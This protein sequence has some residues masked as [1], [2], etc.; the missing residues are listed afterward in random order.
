VNVLE[1]PNGLAELQKLGVRSV[2]VLSRGDK[3]TFGQSTK[4]IVEFLGLNENAGPL[5]S[6]DELA[7]RLD[8]FMGAA[9]ELIPLMPY[10][11]LAT[12]VPGRP[13]SYRTLAFHLFRVVDAF[14]GANEGTTLVQDMFREEPAP[15]ADAATLV[16]WGETVRRRFADWWRKGDAS[17]SKPLPTYYGPQSLHELMERTTWHCG[18]HVRQYMMLL[19]KEG[20]RHREPL[21]PADF[22]K[23]P[24]PTN[25]WDG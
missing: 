12:H 19:D 7:A 14:I 17:P 9:L 23:L 1:D 2:P 25:V 11:K 10:D 6:T 24:M 5:L 22:A 21:G 20:V 4:Q 15:D 13:R 16:T 18:Q 3:Y 8:K